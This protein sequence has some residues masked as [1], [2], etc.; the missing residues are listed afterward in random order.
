MQWGDKCKHYNIV[1]VTLSTMLSNQGQVLLIGGQ[2]QLPRES[3]AVIPC[4]QL[5]DTQAELTSFSPNACWV[6]PQ[7]PLQYWLF[8]GNVFLHG[9]HFKMVSSFHLNNRQQH[10]SMKLM[11]Y[12]GTEAW[13]TQML[14][15]INPIIQ[16][17]ALCPCSR[18]PERND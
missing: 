8:K 9:M 2:V 12:S 13:H 14:L 17:A 5:L 16:T 3:K 1:F 10:P 11:Y 6:L 4:K 15:M 7:P 18:A